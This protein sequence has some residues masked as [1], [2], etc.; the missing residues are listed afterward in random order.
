MKRILSLVLA[1]M[2]L[3]A[4]VEGAPLDYLKTVFNKPVPIQ[5]PSI[6]VLVAYDKPGAV[7]E[8]KGRYLLFDP[9]TNS[10][11]S[12]RFIGKRKFIQ[13][14][15]DGLRWGEEFP[16]LHQLLIVPQDP[17]VTTIVDGIEYRGGIYVYD[18]EGTIAVV[19]EVNV[20][21]YLKSILARR[22]LEPMDD[23]ALAAAVIAVR[24][25]AYY[26]AANPQT[27]FWAVDGQK[28]GYQG[29]A[30][31]GRNVPVEDAIQATRY[32][33]MNEGNVSQGVVHPIPALWEQSG[34]EKAGVVA[35]IK[36]E[37]ANAMSKDGAHAAQILGKA[38][39]GST[40]ILMH[41]DKKQR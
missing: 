34:D 19:N 18:V 11:I 16:G 23:E 12:T 9:R 5:P 1:L 21:D 31:T 20:E 41:H 33:I 22:F 35:Q 17:T 8:V 25:N 28:V 32:L 7:L 26:Q 15:N 37:E 24:T 39:P 3:I 36:L 2:P 27:P 40:L 30:V 10:Y 29:Y 13:A 4:T 6:K 14:I 38:F